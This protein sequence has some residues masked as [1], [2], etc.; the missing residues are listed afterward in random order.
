MRFLMD[1]TSVG[2]ASAGNQTQFGALFY[3]TYRDTL[4]ANLVGVAEE[5][6]PELTSVAGREYLVVGTV[7]SGI[8]EHIS[9]D[10]NLRKKYVFRLNYSV[11]IVEQVDNYH[12]T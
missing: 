8:L 11:M 12:G 7:L 4:N 3:A 6:I 5:I 2:H 1:K 10:R 9:K